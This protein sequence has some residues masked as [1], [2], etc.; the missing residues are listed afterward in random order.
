MEFITGLGIG[1]L[2]GG[3]IT[4]FMI[5]LNRVDNKILEEEKKQHPDG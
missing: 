4:L 2:I 3:G 5:F 1:V